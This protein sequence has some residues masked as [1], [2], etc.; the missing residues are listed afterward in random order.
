MKRYQFQHSGIISQSNQ[1]M[2]QNDYQ[3]NKKY[4]EQQ[5]LQNVKMDGSVCFQTNGDINVYPCPWESDKEVT[6]GAMFATVAASRWMLT[7]AHG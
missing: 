2:K 4:Q 1:K 3:D 7:D 5:L 6:D